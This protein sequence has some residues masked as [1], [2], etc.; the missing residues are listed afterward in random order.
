MHERDTQIY[1]YMHR[2]IQTEMGTYTAP[3]RIIHVV[4]R[5]P[6]SENEAVPG[7]HTGR[8]EGVSECRS[9]GE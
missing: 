1:T 6:E 5:W 9:A 7:V 2:Y 8:R 3:L 4:Q